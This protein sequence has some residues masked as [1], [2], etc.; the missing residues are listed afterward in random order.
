MTT[1]LPI[2]IH[3]L[4]FVI[5]QRLTGFGLLL[6][7]S[8]VAAEPETESLLERL[9]RARGEIRTF[10]ASF[11]QTRHL[12]LL[13][14]PALSRGRVL[15]R[16]E[17]DAG[18]GGYRWAV[19]WEVVEPEPVIH[20]L[21]AEELLTL[22]PAEREGARTPLPASFAPFLALIGRPGIGP[23]LRERFNVSRLPE[24][25]GGADG[26]RFPEESAPGAAGLVLRP[27]DPAAAK[28]IR[29]IRLLL[30]PDTLQ[31]TH[32][33]V[34][35]PGGDRTEVRFADLKEDIP[36]DADLFTP[37]LS[38]YRMSAPR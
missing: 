18:G 28:T 4:S 11:E 13:A 23:A 1:H 34:V 26:F 12:D 36:L 17:E 10:S 38:G 14:R 3:H 30:A 8:G 2:G 29:E 6:F 7:A 31:V 22:H 21:R 32:L 16:R 9:E 20:L 35:E 24:S 19:R 27:R 5:M 33:A 15:A 25:V 37:D